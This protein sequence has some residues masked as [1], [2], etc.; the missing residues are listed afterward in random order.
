MTADNKRIGWLLDGLVSQVSG[1]EDALVLTRDGLTVAASATLD[2][3][4]AERL[5]A[6]AAGF[7]SLGRGAVRHLGAE[8]VHQIIV[9]MDTSFLFITAAG[10]GTCLAVVSS[11]SADVGLIAYEMA[12]LIKRVD[13]YLAV[14]PRAVSG[15]G[16]VT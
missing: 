2:R 16:E 13:D 8:Q 9:E 3:E 7:H 15:G 1:I 14:P 4:D 5:A 6:I 10:E 11:A 12:M